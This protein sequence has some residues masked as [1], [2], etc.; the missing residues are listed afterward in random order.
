MLKTQV[1]FQI[2]KNI[3]TAGNSATYK[4][5]C[6]YFIDIV[7]L[8][9]RCNFLHRYRTFHP[10]IQFFPFV[11][12]SRRRSNPPLQNSRPRF[13]CIQL[14]LQIFFNQKKN[15]L[16]KFLIN[17]FVYDNFTNFRRSA[18]RNRSQILNCFIFYRN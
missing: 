13:N 7:F 3:F 8:A 9:K 2:I 4:N 11:I 16:F 5:G 12:A 1:V 10:I 17:R 6:K 15:K 14:H 18:F